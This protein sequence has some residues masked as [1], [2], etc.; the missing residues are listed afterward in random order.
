MAELLTEL[1]EDETYRNQVAESCFEVTQNPS[2][3]W[4]R[5]AEGFQ[6]AMEELSK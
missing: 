3:R 4:D 2:Y 5:I 1:Y 6:R